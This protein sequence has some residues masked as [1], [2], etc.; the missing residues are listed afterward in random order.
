MLLYHALYHKETVSKDYLQRLQLGNNSKCYANYKLLT[1]LNSK[2]YILTE[3][4]DFSVYFNGINSVKRKLFYKIYFINIKL[5]KLILTFLSYYFFVFDKFI[6]ILFFPIYFLYFYIKYKAVVFN[7][8]SWKNRTKLF[9]GK[10]NNNLCFIKSM[11]SDFIQNEE[12]C[13]KQIYNIN[14][15]L[16]PKTYYISRHSIFPHIVIEYLDNTIPF[17]FKL[18][19]SNNKQSLEQL[20]ENIL[21]TFSKLGI[22]HGDLTNKNVLINKKNNSVFVIDFAFARGLNLNK[23]KGIRGYL[24]NYSIGK[25]IRDTN[26]FT[27]DKTALTNLFSF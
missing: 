27:C 25:S 13:L 24:I 19:D 3:P 4:Y 22:V 12:Y 11:N 9:I 6:D 10:Y 17:S 18:Y 16:V 26:G 7:F 8:L 1:Y 2:N 23:P 21:H 15:S 5:K 14:S 20:C